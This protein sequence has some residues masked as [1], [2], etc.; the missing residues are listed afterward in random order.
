MVVLISTSRLKKTSIIMQANIS[1]QLTRPNCVHWKDKSWY[2]CVTHEKW[3]IVLQ[4]LYT[5]DIVYIIK[6]TATAWTT[7]SLIPQT[8][9]DFMTGHLNS[10]VNMTRL[11]QT[12]KQ[13]ILR[14]CCHCARAFESKIPR[15]V[16]K[17]F[18]IAQFKTLTLEV[19]LLSHL[20]FLSSR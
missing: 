4:L 6:Q 5:Q 17:Q 2:M 19:S 18:L 13:S 15:V 8:V 11:P 1:V 10:Q 20:R 12:S 3:R 9:N 16:C 7:I 14:M